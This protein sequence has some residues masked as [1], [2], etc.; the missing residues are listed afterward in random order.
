M[1]AVDDFLVKVRVALNKNTPFNFFELVSE[2]EKICE[3]IEGAQEG[4][5]EP[6]VTLKGE[7]F[8][9]KG[10]RIL[11][12]TYIEGNAYI[13][14]N[15]K[16]GPNAYLRNGVIL[17]GDNH[18]ANSEIK[19]SVILRGSNIPHFSY[20]G[21]SI[22]GENC[23]LGAGTKIANLRFDDANIEIEIDGKKISSGRRK[24]GACLG[25]TVKTG[26]NSSINCGA[27]IKN[28]SKILPNS[29]FK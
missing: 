4:K 9:G 29:L 7:V 6:N 14:Q 3:T 24:L 17:E 19:N 18:V 22:I 28:G 21:D 11:S 8:L 2:N 26:I 23:N 12:G 10:S 25:H 5:I 27:Q 13:G 20:V 1:R 16:I 15:C